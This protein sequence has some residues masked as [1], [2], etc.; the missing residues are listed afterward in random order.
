M[1]LDR[2]DYVDNRACDHG[3]GHYV[4][5]PSDDELAL[6]FVYDQRIWLDLLG[7]VDDQ[8]VSVE[9]AHV[10][11]A[12]GVHGHEHGCRR[13]LNAKG[14]EVKGLFFVALGGAGESSYH[15]NFCFFFV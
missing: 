5:N 6:A 8:K 4:P 2:V 11:V 1:F 7:P 15:I 9:N 12:V 14:V 3:L 10:V 13:M